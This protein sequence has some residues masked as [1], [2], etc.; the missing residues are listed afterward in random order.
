MTVDLAIV[1]AGPAGMAAAVMAADLGLDT[2]LIDEQ[3]APGGQI[4]R[5]IERI[6]EGADRRSPLGRHYLACRPL[7]A[8]PRLS[9][10][11]AARGGAAREP[12]RLPPGG[13][14]LAYRLGGHPVAGRR[15]PQR[16]DSRAPSPAR[17][18]RDRAAGPDPGLDP[19]RRDD[20]GRSADLAEDRRP[21]AGGPG[22]ARRA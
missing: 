2:V 18:R 1:G 10:R 3:E 5:G 22:G 4:Y 19:A 9:R 12:G 16:D 20:R 6:P 14:G 8:R 21:R 17:D 13:D 15:E 11:P 7:A